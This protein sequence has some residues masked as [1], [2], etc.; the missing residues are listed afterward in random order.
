M[1][2]QKAGEYNKAIEMQEKLLMVTKTMGSDAELPLI[3]LAVM[4]LQAGKE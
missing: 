2:L 3:D 1:V 4:H